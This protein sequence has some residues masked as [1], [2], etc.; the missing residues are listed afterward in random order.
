MPYLSFGMTRPSNASQQYPV[1]PVVNLTLAQLLT[2][3]LKSGQPVLTFAEALEATTSVLQ[4]EIKEPVPAVAEL[5]RFRPSDSARLKF[6]SFLPANSPK[7]TCSRPCMGSD[8]QPL[9]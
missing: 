1:R 8:C 4:V 3:T 6:S 7:P 2:V 5:L 9:G